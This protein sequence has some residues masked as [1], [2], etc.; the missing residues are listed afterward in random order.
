[1]V[2]EDLFGWLIPIHVAE[3]FEIQY[4]ADKVDSTQWAAFVV[5]VLWHETDK[6]VSVEFNKFWKN[7]KPEWGDPKKL[8]KYF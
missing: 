7:T 6:G 8:D 3:K 2:G 4:N 5:F 1:M